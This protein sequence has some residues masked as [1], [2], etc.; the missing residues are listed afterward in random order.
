MAF[1]F[2]GVTCSLWTI[3]PSAHWSVTQSVTELVGQSLGQHIPLMVCLILF[4]PE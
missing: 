2:I 3:F 4:Q 1:Y